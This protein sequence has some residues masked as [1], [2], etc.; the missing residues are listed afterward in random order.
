MRPLASI[1]FL[2]ITPAALA[3][4]LP[5]PAT[6][7]VGLGGAYTAMARGYEAV[8]WN[9]GLLAARGR[10]GFSMS[11]PRVV[12][13]FGSNAYGLSDLRRY[14]DETLTDADKQ[15]LL[16]KVDTTL[17]IRSVGGVTPFA[18]QIGPFGL[19]FGTTGDMVG[20]LGKDA[21]E[22]MLF[23]NAS[24]SGPGEFFTAAG[25]FA[26]GW[27][28][29]TLAAS[30]ALPVPLS[31]GRLS[32]GITGKKI[33]GHGLALGRETSSSFQV[34]PTFQVAAAGHVIYTDLVDDWEFDGLNILGKEGSPGSGFGVDLGGVLDLTGARNGLRIGVALVNVIGTMDWDASR[35]RYDRFSYQVTQNASGTVTDTR[36][37]DSL[38]T[39]A[40][41]NGDPTARALRDS[42]LD[43][44]GF[45]KLVRAGVALRL[46][47][48]TLG[49]D[50]QLRLSEGLDRQPAQQVAVGA[51]YVLL[52]FLPLRAGIATDF[53]DAFTL[54][55][56]TGLNL[57]PVKLDVSAANTGGSDRP[58]VR[59][60]A[61]L[62]LIF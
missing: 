8:A 43:N 12:F 54:S 10:P 1:A 20:G 24:R 28:A 21:I 9:P 60:G 37:Q 41:I 51:E 13:D 15:T 31:M 36:I 62:G 49:A 46:G 14:A 5:D 34:N 19:S 59:V 57:G 30:F 47:P 35:F 38:I 18:L 27:S 25:S 61:G 16:D 55:G 22:L 3:A 58:G 6:R 32:V 2:A 42:L 26:Q 33:W 50:A 4:Q 11:L 45:S 48:F 56:G 52:G 40:Q 53:S 7:A 44:A 17:T 29:S 39:E 23:G